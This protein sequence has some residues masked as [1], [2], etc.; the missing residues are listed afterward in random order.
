MYRP[1]FSLSGFP[2]WAP[3]ALV[4]LLAALLVGCA[5]QPGGEVAR[6]SSA[7]DGTDS[8]QDP[9]TG[10]KK[11][12]PAAIVE[13]E[14]DVGFTVTEVVSI[15]SNVR[16]DHNEALGL[17]AREDFDRGIALLLEVI[18]KVP[19]ATGPLVDLGIAYRQAGSF[20]EA[21]SSLHDAL[22]LTPDHPVAHNELGIVYRRQGRFEAARQSYEQALAI[23]PGFHYARRN[24]AVLCDLYLADLHCALEHYEIY[25]RSVSDDRE[26]DIWIGDIRNRIAPE[27]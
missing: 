21:E 23:Y 11:T 17:L 20:A 24:L 16:A 19:D 4:G 14:T 26:V 22:D 25:R 2:G 27:E 7:S 8:V 1:L 5:A 9:R 3:L 18:D 15:G 10:V 6:G 12:G 13:V